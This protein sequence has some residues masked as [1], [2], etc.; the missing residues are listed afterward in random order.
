MSAL[1]LAPGAATIAL[2]P[3]E[4][5][6]LETLQYLDAA[7]AERTGQEPIVD[8]SRL[9]LFARSGHAFVA[10]PRDAAA[11]PCGMVLA[12]V[13]WDGTRPVVRAT[14]LVAR[15]DDAAVL[16]RLLEGLVKSAYDA[17]VYD[18]VVES[19]ERDGA[20]GAALRSGGFALRPVACFERVLGSRGSVP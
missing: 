19:P 15:D 8:R 10:C 20:G 6:D 12:H 4:I 16:A 9:G 2:R 18:I 7:Y 11:E 5:G 1:E 17:A 13:V 3:L 14:R